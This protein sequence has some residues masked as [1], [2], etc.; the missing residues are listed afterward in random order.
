M[1][2]SEIIKRIDKNR[3]LI[4]NVL[5]QESIDVMY[6]IIKQKVEENERLLS[7]LKQITGEELTIK[8]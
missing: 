7:K 1:I 4:N 3:E 8:P 6:I 2:E 5:H